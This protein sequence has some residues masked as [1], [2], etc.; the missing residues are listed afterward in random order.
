MEEMLSKL[1]EVNSNN[2]KITLKS[3]CIDCMDEVTINITRTSGGFGLQGGALFKYPPYGCVA[4]CHFCYK[5][6]PTLNVFRNLRELF[7]SQIL[8]DPFEKY[9]HP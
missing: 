7:D 5:V 8:F 9:F 6:N 3:K 1:F 2:S 4:K